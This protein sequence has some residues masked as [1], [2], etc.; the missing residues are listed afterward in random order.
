MQPTPDIARLWTKPD[1]STC[2]LTRRGT[3]LFLSV[4]RDGRILMEK[5]VES[6]TEAMD[7]ALMWKTLPTQNES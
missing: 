3:T 5:A 6:P 7:L 2:V 4:Q 1:G